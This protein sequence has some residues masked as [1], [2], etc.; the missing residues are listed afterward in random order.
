MFAERHGHQGYK[1]LAFVL[2][3]KMLT[4]IFLKFFIW[5]NMFCDGEKMIDRQKHSAI[6]V[7]VTKDHIA[8]RIG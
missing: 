3:Y 6:T 7:T 5:V 1:M 4:K 2:T 8:Y